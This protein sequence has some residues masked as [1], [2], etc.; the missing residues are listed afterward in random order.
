MTQLDHVR[1]TMSEWPAM[2]AHICETIKRIGRP[3]MFL[4]NPS[5][6]EPE[7][8][9]VYQEVCA[10]WHGYPVSWHDSRISVGSLD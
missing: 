7:R 5:S 2:E 3:P 10:R 4:L 6:T 9:A 8:K 1:K